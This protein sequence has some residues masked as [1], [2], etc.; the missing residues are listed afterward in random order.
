MASSPYEPVLGSRRMPGAQWFLGACLNYAEHALRHERQDEDALL[1]LSERVAQR[2]L[3]RLNDRGDC[4]VLG[5]SDAGLSDRQ[6][7]A[8]G[9][10]S[11]RYSRGVMPKRARNTRPKCVGLLKP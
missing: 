10:G 11:R 9:G 6:L 1:Y 5:R 7:A 8:A 3:F 2:R 4:F